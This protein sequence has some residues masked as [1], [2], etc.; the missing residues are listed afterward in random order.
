MFSWDV[1]LARLELDGICNL[2]QDFRDGSNISISRKKTLP[3]LLRSPRSCANSLW[4]H[5]LAARRFTAMQVAG[6]EKSKELTK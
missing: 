3:F 6:D 5:A 2:L 1:F 4:R